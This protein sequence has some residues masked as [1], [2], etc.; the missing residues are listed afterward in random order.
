MRNFELFGKQ[1]HPKFYGGK[2]TNMIKTVML[3]EG[4]KYDDG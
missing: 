2:N 4:L 3:K 1:F